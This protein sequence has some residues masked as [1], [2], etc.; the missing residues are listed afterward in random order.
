M[1]DITMWN[2]R[3]WAAVTERMLRGFAIG[4]LLV[5]GGNLFDVFTVD[6]PRA[7]GF[8]LGGALLSLLMS[9][10]GN[11]TSGNGPS[12]VRAEKVATPQPVAPVGGQI[13]SNRTGKVYDDVPD[14]G[15]RD[16]GTP[17]V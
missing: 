6:W 7:L 1:D 4:V 10:A 5:V 12:F 14:R 2:R 8:G 16:D 11:V 13:I 17:I 3:Y 15:M 9:L